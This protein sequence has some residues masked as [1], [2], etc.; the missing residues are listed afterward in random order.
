MNTCKVSDMAMWQQSKEICAINWE[1][2][3]CVEEI[4]KLLY[5][6]PGI[7]SK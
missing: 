1:L 2:W 3:P 7:K 4:R 6:T 5:E